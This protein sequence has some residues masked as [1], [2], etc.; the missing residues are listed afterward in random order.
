M[1]KINTGSFNEDHELQAVPEA[2]RRSILTMFALMLGFTFFSA[3]MWTGQKLEAGLNLDNFIYAV[4]IG[5]AILG[6]YTS[7]LAYIGAKTGLTMD[8]LSQHTFG[9]KG[10]FLPSLLISFTQIGWFGVGVAMF[11]LPVAHL[12]SPDTSWLPMFLVILAGALMTTS[13]FIG[14]KALTL[15]SYIS[16][17]LIAILGIMSMYL[18]VSGSDSSISAKFAE[19]NDMSLFTGV[20]L[21]VGSFIS[22]GTAT[23]NFTRFAKNPTHAVLTTVVAFFLGNGL[24]FAFGAISGAFSNGSDIFDVMIGLNLGFFAILVLGL[25]IWTTNDNA[26]YTVGLGL[27]NITKQPKR[28]MVLIAG[29]VG[30]LSAIWLYN[31]FVGWL[32]VL[33]A[34]LPPI[35]AILIV[36][37]FMH[38]KEYQIENEVSTEVNVFAIAGVILGALIANNLSWG[39]SSINGMVIAAVCYIIGEKFF[40]SKK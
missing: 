30:T 24:M 34:T 17:P 4:L 7:T 1:S 18:A 31:N 26:L 35:G 27:S 11:A 14:I 12:I 25:N 6:V 13:A 15:I 39:I 23:P 5:G 10:S 21:V 32:S 20:G 9:K 8:L 37:Y 38:R 16:V 22:G 3:S 40:K 28:P 36:G 19:N 33:N 29:I 2:H